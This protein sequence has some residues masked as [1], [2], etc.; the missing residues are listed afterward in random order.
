MRRGKLNKKRS[1]Y[2]S[3]RPNF[4]SANGKYLLSSSP[5]EQWQ[6]E[7]RDHLYDWPSVVSWRMKDKGWKCVCSQRVPCTSAQLG[8]LGENTFWFTFLSISVSLFWERGKKLKKVKVMLT[9]RSVLLQG[10]RFC[11]VCGIES[12]R[13]IIWGQLIEGSHQQF[14][15]AW[16]LQVARLTSTWL[17]PELQSDFR[18]SPSPEQGQTQPWWALQGEPWLGAEG[19]LVAVVCSITSHIVYS[20]PKL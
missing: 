10:L 3:E 2:T 19:Q 17:F 20:F 11:C 7:G 15:T 1:G 6:W 14:C 18:G 4:S 13:G 12:T 16:T 9:K 8:I 5:W